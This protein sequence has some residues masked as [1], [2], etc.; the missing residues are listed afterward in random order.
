MREGATD[1][2]GLARRLALEAAGILGPAFL[3]VLTLL[4]FRAPGASHAGEPRPREEPVPLSWK[5]HPDRGETRA[6]DLPLL[7]GRYGELKRALEASFD[8]PQIDPS[9]MLEEPYDAGLPACTRRGERQET[10]ARPVPPGLRGRRLY[11]LRAPDPSRVS[12]P[13]ELARGPAP[14]VFL[15]SAPR[16]R[17]V[18]LVSKNLRMSVSLAG[19]DFARSL[20]VRCAST[21]LLIRE[22][23]NGAFLVENP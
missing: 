16:V 11:F 18:A 22:D 10:F 6:L 23:G 19:A 5:T 15:L 4:L 3:A 9:R 8:R 13:E 7:R 2:A 20:G 1:R 17:D 14:E 21:W 12:L